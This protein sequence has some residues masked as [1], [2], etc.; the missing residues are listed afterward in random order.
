MDAR[1]VVWL[2]LTVQVGGLAVDAV[3]HDPEPGHK[4]A[5][6]MLLAHAGIYLGVAITLAGA[7]RGIRQ[8][9]ADL[10]FVMFTIA[11]LASVVQAV[12]LLVDLATEITSST[13]NVDAAVYVLEL[14]PLL[15]AAVVLSVTAW[16]AGRRDLPGEPGS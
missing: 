12:A 16:N 2:G 7:A 11:G 9:Q 8:Q 3:W 4:S 10:T 1:R 13:V 15:V 5:A 6:D 14:L